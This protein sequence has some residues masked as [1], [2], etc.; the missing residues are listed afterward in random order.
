M[1]APRRAR[2]QCP[3]PS[4]TFPP[5]GFPRLFRFLLRLGD[6]V[7]A[8]PLLLRLGARARALGRKLQDRILEEL[9]QAEHR[10]GLRR[11]ERFG[12]HQELLL[13][14]GVV[15]LGEIFSGRLVKHELDAKLSHAILLWAFSIARRCAQSRSRSPAVPMFSSRPLAPRRHR[16]KTKSS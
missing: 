3:G 12:A 4:S 13:V 6:A 15:E 7:A 5:F 1:P 10:R 11:I 8:P 14:V 9:H 16:G 2:A